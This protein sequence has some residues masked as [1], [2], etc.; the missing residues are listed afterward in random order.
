MKE[1]RGTV[2]EMDGLSATVQMED[3]GSRVVSVPEMLDVE[4]GTT[5]KIA[6]PGDGK[7]IFLWDQ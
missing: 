4:V 6:D 1:E 2:V 5:V 7:P 3:G